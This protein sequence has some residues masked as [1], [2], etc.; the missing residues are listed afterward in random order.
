MIQFTPEDIQR[1]VRIVLYYTAGALTSR[2]IHADGAMW[3]I[4]SGIVLGLANLAWST[5]GMRVNAK[6]TE[7]SRLGDNPKSPVR[8]AVVNNDIEG[9]KIAK[10]VPGVVVAGSLEA[11]KIARAA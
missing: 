1:Y 9:R 2:G 5:Y 11:D 3:E 7:I 6:L 4:V 8:G 10:E